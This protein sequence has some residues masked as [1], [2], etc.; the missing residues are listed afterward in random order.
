MKYSLESSVKPANLRCGGRALDDSVATSQG[1]P[2]TTRD[3]IKIQNPPS[4][5]CEA[6]PPL[7]AGLAM[8]IDIL[9]LEA[10]KNGDGGARGIARRG[11]SRQRHFSR[12]APAEESVRQRARRLA[13]NRAKASQSKIAGVIKIKS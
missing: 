3:R 4:N 8:M 9:A 12:N 5:P 2:C 1:R 11:D 13:L 7:P 10:L 6:I